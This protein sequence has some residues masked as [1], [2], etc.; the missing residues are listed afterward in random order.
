MLGQASPIAIRIADPGD[1]ALL[2]RLGE[3][4]FTQTFAAANTA[5]DLAAYLATAFGPAIQGA[6]L[7]SPRNL[8]L[9]GSAAGQAVAYAQLAR[10]SPPEC[11]RAARPIELLRFYVDAAWHGRGVS[12]ALM[13]HVIAHAAGGGHDALWLGVWERNARAIAF[14]RKWGFELAGSKPFQLGS[15]RQTDH[16]MVRAVERCAP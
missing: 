9:I 7:E 3:A 13:E 5:E 14:Y 16:I 8:F 6:E 15:D 12:H 10:S 2:A 1:A 4:T 11:V